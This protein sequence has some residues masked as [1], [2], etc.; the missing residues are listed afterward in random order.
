[1]SDTDSDTRHT[2]QQS[3][4]PEPPTDLVRFRMS[5][6]NVTTEPGASTVVHTRPDCTHIVET[7]PRKFD[8]FL[9]GEEI[10][11][12]YREIG[13]TTGEPTR[14]QVGPRWCKWCRTRTTTDDEHTDR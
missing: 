6:P 9:P 11:P 5:S 13:G 7:D 4:H 12:Q 1:M 8:V 2:V 14:L 10:D 3:T